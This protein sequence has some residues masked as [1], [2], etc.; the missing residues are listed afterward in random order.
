MLL[1]LVLA[2][3]HLVKDRKSGVLGAGDG[4]G[5]EEVG[6]GKR[7]EQLLY[8]FAAERT[9]VKGWRTQGTI[10]RKAAFANTAIS[11]TGRVLVNW[12]G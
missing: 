10:E 7:A 8:G 3:A 6:R 11:R 9:T 2:L 1:P 12:H 5:L 4:K